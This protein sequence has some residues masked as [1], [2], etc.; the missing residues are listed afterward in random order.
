MPVGPLAP[1]DHPP[2]FC[3]CSGLACT[4]PAE[5]RPA[6]GLH[7]LASFPTGNVSVV[8]PHGAARVVLLSV[9]HLPRWMQ[10]VCLSVCPVLDIRVISSS[11]CWDLC[12]D[13]HA[14]TSVHRIPAFESSGHVCPSRIA[15]SFAK[16]VSHL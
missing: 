13:G 10:P 8:R 11:G 5:G 12:R 16:S 2:A 7:R 3:V 15:G 14:H 4:V 6:R 9:A 1:R